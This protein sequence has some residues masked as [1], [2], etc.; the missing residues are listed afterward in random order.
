[1]KR[2]K[3]DFGYGRYYFEEHEIGD[4]VRFED[5]QSALDARDATIAKLRE[6][7]RRAKRRGMTSVS[8]PKTTTP[9]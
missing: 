1:M 4:W 5:A 8:S 3:V 7:L 9:R 2:F 6:A